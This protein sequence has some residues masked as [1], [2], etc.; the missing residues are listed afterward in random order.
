MTTSDRRTSAWARKYKELFTE[1]VEALGGEQNITP[2]QRDTV[3]NL[4]TLPTVA[5]DRPKI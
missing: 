4:A 5:A 1:F 3:G 2:V